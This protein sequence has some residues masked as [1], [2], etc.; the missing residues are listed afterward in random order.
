LKIAAANNYFVQVSNT[1]CRELVCGR[2]KWMSSI[3]PPTASC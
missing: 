2:K 1:S 3:S